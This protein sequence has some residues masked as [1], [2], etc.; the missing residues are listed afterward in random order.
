VSV[1]TI[2]NLNCDVDV[3]KFQKIH[4]APIGAGIQK[5]A[6]KGMLGAGGATSVVGNDNN[7]THFPSV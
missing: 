6:K 2:Y 3:P 4:H 7:G 5:N 1:G